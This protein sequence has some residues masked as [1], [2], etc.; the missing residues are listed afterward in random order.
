ML[1]QSTS[2]AK[3]CSQGSQFH[4][5]TGRS[6]LVLAHLRPDPYEI[7]LVVIMIKKAS[8]WEAN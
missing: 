8:N 5:G 7:R 6:S 4:S 1:M 3:L 2:G